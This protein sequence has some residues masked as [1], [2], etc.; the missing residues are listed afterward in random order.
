MPPGDERRRTSRISTRLK[1]GKLLSRRGAFIADCA[2][3]DRSA[4]GA[5]VRVFDPATLSGEMILFDETGTVV[6]PARLVWEHGPEAG[7][8]FLAGELPVPPAIVERIAGRYYAV[9]G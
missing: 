3:T 9:P 1:P 6:W 5:R 8:R 4:T 7:L 2:I